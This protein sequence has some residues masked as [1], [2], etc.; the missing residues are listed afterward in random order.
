[1][2]RQISIHEAV[3]IGLNDAAD[4]YDIACLNL[5]CVFTMRFSEG[6]YRILCPIFIIIKN[7]GVQNLI[8]TDSRDSPS[9]PTD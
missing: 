5:E 9:N 6:D 7:M 2:S 3:E 8:L 4:F 1:M